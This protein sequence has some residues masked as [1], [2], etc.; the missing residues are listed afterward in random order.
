MTLTSAVAMLVY[1]TQ[2]KVLAARQNSAV[3]TLES[4][5]EVCRPVDDPMDDLTYFRE[6]ALGSLWRRLPD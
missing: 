6:R 4:E 3:A 5:A 1:F 2:L